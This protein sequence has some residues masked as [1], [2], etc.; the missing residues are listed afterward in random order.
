MLEERLGP[1]LLV[2]LIAS[3]HVKGG[4]ETER[5]RKNFLG[6]LVRKKPPA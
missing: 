3:A 5:R 1:Y 2:G 4:E 6:A